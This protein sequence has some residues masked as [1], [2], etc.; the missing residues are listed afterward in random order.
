MKRVA[1]VAAL[2]VACSLAVIVGASA[3]DAKPSPVAAKPMTVGQAL[4]VL[5]ALRQLDGHQVIIKQGDQTTTVSQPWEFKNGGLRMDIATDV[6]ILALVEQN[7]EKIRQQ[8]VS[9]ILK[10]APG[11][12]AVTPGTPEFEDFVKQYQAALDAPANVPGLVRIKAKDLRLDVNEI[13][14]SVLGAMAP[15]IDREPR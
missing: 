6:A 10:N 4:Q 13:A 11:R 7:V 5:G 2:I 8:I 14:P 3:Q 12:T 15:V 1:V 9:E